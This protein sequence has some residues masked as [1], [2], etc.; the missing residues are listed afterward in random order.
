MLMMMHY[1]VESGAKLELARDA[2]HA[3]IQGHKS[4]SDLLDVQSDHPSDQ[5]ETNSD[6][7]SILFDI[8]RCFSQIMSQSSPLKP[9]DWKLKVMMTLFKY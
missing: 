2:S 1:D 3:L 9:R 8:Y 6:I 5:D 7:I 4:A